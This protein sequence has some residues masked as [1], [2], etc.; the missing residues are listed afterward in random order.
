MANAID[1]NGKK[2]VVTGGA[3]G[4]GRAIVARLLSSGAEV[5]IW[6]RD[7]AR[8]EQTAGELRHACRV[9][10]AACDV[11]RLAEVETARDGT[12]KEFGRID[13]LV[14]TAGIAGP[15]VKTWEY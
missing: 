11:T 4:I 7:R 8:A 13:I 10:A 1:L 9:V 2:A 15:N 3:Q 6:D 12:L 5:A 14:N